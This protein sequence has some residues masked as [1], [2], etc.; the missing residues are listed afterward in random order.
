MSLRT[1]ALDTE[2][3]IYVMHHLGRRFS[4]FFAGEPVG[5]E[6]SGMREA[7]DWAIT[8]DWFVYTAGRQSTKPR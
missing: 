4:W 3:H 2:G 6:F 1:S 8:Q 7:K 5:P